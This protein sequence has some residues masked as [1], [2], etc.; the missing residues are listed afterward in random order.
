MSKALRYI[1]VL[2]AIILLLSSCATLPK[3]EQDSKMQTQ[4]KRP[5]P[6]PD[7]SKP[8]LASIYYFMSGSFMH[9]N[10]ELASAD[11]LLSM[12]L[13]QDPGSFQVRKLLFVNALQFYNYAQSPEAEQRAREMLSIARASY[14]FD[15][16]M[17]TVAYNGYRNLQDAEGV[18]WALESLLKD[19]PKAQ[20][21]IW[22]YIHQMEEGKKASVS[23][24]EKALKAESDIPEIEFI[25]A[26]LYL[27]INPKRAR[28]ILLN[29]ARSRAGE[30]Q[31][32]ELYR[33]ANQEDKLLDHY[34]NYS[35]PE[36]KDKIREYLMFLQK[37]SF[38]DLALAHLDDILLTGDAELIE[39]SSY[40]AFL[41][42]NLPAQ[43]KIYQYLIAKTPAP[44]EDSS[45]AALLLLHYI[46]HPEFTSGLLM[47]D[48]IYQI[49][50]LVYISYLYASQY[51]YTGSREKEYQ[52]VFKKL[53]DYSQKNL[54]PS[55]IKDFL[56]D[57]TAFLAGLFD[58]ESSSAVALAEYFIAKGYGS[59]D[60]FQLLLQHYSD[61]GDAA[62]QI[63]ILRESLERYP[64]SASIKNNL[65]YILLNYPEHLDEAERLIS[66]ALQDDPQNASFQDSWAWL[67]YQRGR[68][69][70]AYEYL[71]TV[72]ANAEPNAELL[73]HAGMICQAAG[74]KEE[75]LKFFE[76][77][78]QIQPPGEYHDK[79]SGELKRLGAEGK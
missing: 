33:T 72:L 11:Q 4:T 75:A 22:E 41:E 24:L 17:L 43:G 63:E 58:S 21:Y 36:D 76:Q 30:L 57:H 14:D 46:V 3:P 42:N 18:S 64:S 34:A 15:Q 2:L 27:D 20:V 16:E 68:Y 53:Y 40:L 65:G 78:L 66:E 79:A 71:P 29:S 62:A 55:L 60:D 23:L 39:A 37:Y 45:I 31:L 51:T 13:S 7:R 1:L 19:Y 26:T 5:E 61:L 9:F 10:G 6:L 35:Y 59:E 73:Y 74:Q 54:P 67:L 32:L 52:K 70:A 12:A 69:K 56:T 47:T 48:K 38:Y 8:N 28:Q 49:K 25:V 44:A 50:D 77:L